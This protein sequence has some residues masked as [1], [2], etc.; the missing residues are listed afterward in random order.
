MGK[1]SQLELFQFHQ[2]QESEDAGRKNFGRRFFAFIRIHEKAIS[3]IIILLIISLVSFSLGVEKGKK[4]VKSNGIRRIDKIQPT[5]TDTTKLAAS[6]D[7][8]DNQDQKIASAVKEVNTA[9][10]REDISKYTIQVASFKSKGYAQK[11]V[12]RLAKRGMQATIVR[13][14][15]YVVV[16]VGDF[17]QKKEADVSLNQLKQTYRDCFIRRL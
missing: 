12:A 9:R 7:I 14:G 4:I 5:Q 8:I 10:E 1:Q 3:I 17:S 16:Y 2:L 6:A 15:N 13:K 11:E